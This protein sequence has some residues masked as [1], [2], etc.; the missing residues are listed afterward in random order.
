M[1]PLNLAAL[2]VCAQFNVGTHKSGRLAIKGIRPFQFYVRHIPPS[3][4]VFVN[5]IIFTSKKKKEKPI[6]DHCR[7]RF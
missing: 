6:Y 3:N 7:R 4:L 5:K 2:T 1:P